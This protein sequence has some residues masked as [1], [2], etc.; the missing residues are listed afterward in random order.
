ML[1]MQ[2]S[3]EGQNRIMKAMMLFLSNPDEEIS[4][5]LRDKLEE[6]DKFQGMAMLSYYQGNEF[7][8][9]WYVGDSEDHPRTIGKK[10]V[11]VGGLILHPDKKW[12]L[13]T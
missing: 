11:A 8:V 2:N 3:I 10:P 13:H 4:R 5:G 6:L 9:H 7:G 12:R 1:I